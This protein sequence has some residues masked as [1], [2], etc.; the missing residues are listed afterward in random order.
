MS[1]HI[2]YALQKDSFKNLFFPTFTSGFCLLGLYMKMCEE[3][4]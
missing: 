3:K 2:A 1:H 4:K